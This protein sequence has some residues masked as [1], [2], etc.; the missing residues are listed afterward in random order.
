M[1][2]SYYRQKLMS[3]DRI[4]TM[5]NL[6]K[7][8]KLLTYTT[9]GCWWIRLLMLNSWIAWRDYGLKAGAQCSNIAVAAAAAVVRW[10]WNDEKL[11]LIFFKQRHRLPKFFA[12]LQAQLVLITHRHRKGVV[13]F[14]GCQHHLQSMRMLLMPRMTAMIERQKN[15]SDS[16]LPRQRH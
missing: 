13:V 14:V 11:F 8:V 5:K 9:D 15:H 3:F 4:L 10:S 12:L 7:F 6:C 1:I 16:I 2:I